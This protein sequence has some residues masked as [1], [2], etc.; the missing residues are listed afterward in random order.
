MKEKEKRA[1]TEREEDRWKPSLNT[2]DND[3]P[4]RKFNHAH[5]GGKYIRN[6]VTISIDRTFNFSI[7]E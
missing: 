4:G 3:I 5:M 2:E 6:V 1:K 7:L